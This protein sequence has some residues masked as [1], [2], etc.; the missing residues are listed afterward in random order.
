MKEEK[1]LKVSAIKNGTVID[2]IPAGNL[3]KVV[4]ILALNRCKSQ[5][6]LGNNLESKLLGAKAIIKVANRFFADDEMNRIALVAPQ[7][8]FN[9]IEDY[10]VME[11]RTVELPDTIVGIAK[12]MNPMCVTNH[13]PITTKFSVVS[14]KDVLLQC[15]YCDKITD[16]EHLVII[17]N[18]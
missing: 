6:T 12:C 11:K 10:E 1:H 13:Q 5:L 16:Q 2:H 8:K 7:A 9:I 17:K 3:F 14:K 18:G 4:E 15:C